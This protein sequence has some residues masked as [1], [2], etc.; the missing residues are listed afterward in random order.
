MHIYCVVV[1]KHLHQSYSHGPNAWWCFGH[2]LERFSIMCRMEKT[3]GVINKMLPGHVQEQLINSVRSNNGAFK[4]S[5]FPAQEKHPVGCQCCRLGNIICASELMKQTGEFLSWALLERSDL[6]FS[7]T[8]NLQVACFQWDLISVGGHGPDSDVDG[9]WDDLILILSPLGGAEQE[10]HGWAGR[11]H[12]QG[13]SGGCGAPVEICW[14]GLKLLD[15]WLSHTLLSAGRVVFW[16]SFA[17]LKETC[18][19]RTPH[20]YSFISL[21]FVYGCSIEISPLWDEERFTVSCL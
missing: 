7:S 21:F 14:G 20:L 10:Q 5:A 12:L 6:G 1:L 9:F 19:G 15:V 17:D 4:P 18:A 3:G 11:T 16:G 8:G 2:C 13:W